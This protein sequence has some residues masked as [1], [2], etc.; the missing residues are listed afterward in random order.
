MN[1][2]SSDIFIKDA[3]IN[4]VLD[5]LGI[6]LQELGTLNEHCSDLFNYLCVCKEEEI[7]GVPV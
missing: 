7:R 1:I 5:D 4:I 3:V 2:T 6:T